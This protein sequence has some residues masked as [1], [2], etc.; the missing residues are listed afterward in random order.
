MRVISENKNDATNSITGF[1]YSIFFSGCS[2]GCE[3]CFS[4]QT[5]IYE[6]G[7]EIN[8][9]DLFKKIKNSRHKNVSLIGGD[10]FYE[11]NR[12]EVI[13]LIKLI[14]N[15]TNKNIYVWTGYT[16]KEVSTWIDLNFIDYLI[17]GKFK[18]NKRDIRLTLRGSSN[19]KIYKKGKDITNELD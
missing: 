6:N 18:L 15:E 2:H 19:Q 4:P 11:K 10:P 17:D 14:K 7:Y 3:G 9:F 16:S 5:W 1:T 12:D 13:E 8:V